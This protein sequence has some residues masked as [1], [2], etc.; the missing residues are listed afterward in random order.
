MVKYE[1][2]YASRY[3]SVWN[4]NYLPSL[5]RA[6]IK[7]LTGQNPI[8]SYIFRASSTSLP[9]QHSVFLFLDIRCGLVLRLDCVPYSILSKPCLI[10]NTRWWE[11]KIPAPEVG[12]RHKLRWRLRNSW[13][14]SE[15]CD[16]VK[17]LTSSYQ[18]AVGVKY[19]DT[20]DVRLPHEAFT[21]SVSGENS[22]SFRF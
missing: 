15:W 16:D 21:T 14:A 10:R 20:T 5:Y 4:D 6:T 19:C 22:S 8:V 13:M 12:N 11:R 1:F 9:G 2:T 3:C 17:F 18:S 7:S